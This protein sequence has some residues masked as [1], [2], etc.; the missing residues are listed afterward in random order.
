[1]WIA[2]VLPPLVVPLAVARPKACPRCG[3]GV[4]LR[5]HQRTRRRLAGVAT[6]ANDLGEEAVTES[7]AHRF[8]CTACGRT[9]TTR[10]FNRVDRSRVQAFIESEVVVAYCLGDLPAQTLLD[11]RD[12]GTPISRASLFRVLARHRD[13]EL[14]RLHRANRRADH[15]ASARQRPRI[16]IRGANIPANEGAFREMLE[17]R[18]VVVAATD[19]AL[20]IFVAVRSIAILLRRR[21]DALAEATVAWLRAYLDPL[22]SAGVLMYPTRRQLERAFPS[23][24]TLP[25]T[26]AA[27][28][29]VA[30]SLDVKDDLRPDR[31]IARTALKSA[32][33]VLTADVEAWSRA[34]D[35]PR[36]FRSRLA[37]STGADVSNEDI[38]D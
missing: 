19:P 13:G 34:F 15:A 6:I 37:S 3:A 24:E 9:W 11:L 10:E 26:S 8:R 25:F 28:D 2:I 4:P 21:R 12:R 14:E 27:E 18:P 38:Y 22:G 1:M 33:R 29:I 23:Y 35:A 20:G 36:R 31:P 5:L 7:W 30:S 17:A 16:V 32:V